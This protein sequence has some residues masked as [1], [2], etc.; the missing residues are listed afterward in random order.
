MAI[1]YGTGISGL[2][3]W[4]FTVKVNTVPRPETG[5]ATSGAL[6][7]R[8]SPAGGCTQRAQSSQYSMSSG[9]SGTTNTV[10]SIDSMV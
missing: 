2:Y 7:V 10:H 5:R 6:H 4:W 8:H 9:S 3:G 1:T